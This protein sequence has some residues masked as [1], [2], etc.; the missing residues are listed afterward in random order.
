MKTLKGAHKTR[1]RTITVLKIG[2]AA[3][4]L[5][6]LGPV[7]GDGGPVVAQARPLEKAYQVGKFRL[8]M[9]YCLLGVCCPS[10]GQL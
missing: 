6:F 4:A 7:A 3:V 5:S 10:D 8:C 9:G 1:P 2:A